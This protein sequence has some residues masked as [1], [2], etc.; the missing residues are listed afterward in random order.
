MIELLYGIGIGVGIM[1]V[2]LLITIS[3]ILASYKRN[4]PEKPIWETQFVKTEYLHWTG[5][6]QE[7]VEKEPISFIFQQN[8][9]GQRNVKI[10]SNGN[11][12]IEMRYT[13]RDPIKNMRYYH[14]SVIPWLAGR[15]V[16]E[17][18]TKIIP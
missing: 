13:N 11:S 17:S 1:I 5:K 12:K 15:D 2:I 7:V 6:K 18:G 14:D 4:K 3:V 9:F 16:N 8:Q 10:E